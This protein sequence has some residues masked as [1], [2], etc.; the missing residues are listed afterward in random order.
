MPMGPGRNRLRQSRPHGSCR[1]RVATGAQQQGEFVG[2]RG[3]AGGGRPVDG[4]SQWVRGRDG[5]DRLGQPV[6]GFAAA[7]FHSRR[8]RSTQ[9]SIGRVNSPS[10][11][12]GLLARKA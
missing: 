7:A 5:L 11:V 2:Q 8:T 1:W 3:L 10:A 12:S 9:V 6:K 4:D